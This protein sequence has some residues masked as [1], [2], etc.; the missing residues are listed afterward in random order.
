MRSLLRLLMVR[1]RALLLV[2]ATIFGAFE[3]LI[4]AI[5]T[6]LDL[7]AVLQNVM[8]AA[9][10]FFSTLIGEQ[11][12]DLTVRG[13]LTF[14]WN[15]P[16]ALALG[17]ATAIALGSRAVAGEIDQGAMELLM[18]QPLSRLRYCAAHALFGAEALALLTLAGV[19]GT[20]IG[21]R[22]YDLEPFGARELALL[23]AL[24]WLLNVAWFA[25]A[26]ALSARGREGGATAMAAF[27]LAL[28]SYLINAIGSVLDSF[29]FA[30]PF[31]LY[32][33]FSPRDILVE[34][35]PQTAAIVVL[36]SVAVVATL[37]G[38]TILQRRDLP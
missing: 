32:S 16:V 28:A 29:A 35:V 12:G 30:L 7:G 38:A 23:G 1:N 14:G 21:Q 18:T 33:W 19:A 36:A 13:I 3:V 4:C 22:L 20:L 6:T 8:T 17:G 31:S 2:S 15:H 26:F 25:I 37:A 10:P 24:Y 9:P 27:F 5:V 11:F 34:P